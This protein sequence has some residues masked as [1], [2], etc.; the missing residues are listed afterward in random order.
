MP[1]RLQ[2]LDRF[3][4]G[5]RA[6]IFAPPPGDRAY[7]VFRRNIENA[8]PKIAQRAFTS[9]ITAYGIATRDPR[10]EPHVPKFFGQVGIS[11]ILGHDGTDIS[12]RYWLDLCYG[13]ARLQADPQECKVTYL[14]EGPDWHLVEPLV[15]Q[16]GEAGID[17]GDASVLYWQTKHPMFVDFRMNQGASAC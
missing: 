3:E 11:D 16:F 12:R 4:E 9:E 5:M 10:L 7:K 17:M 14:F 8:D 15:G 6:D 13:M 1:L 2:V